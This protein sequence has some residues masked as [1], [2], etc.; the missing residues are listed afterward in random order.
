VVRVRTVAEDAA[1]GSLL[2]VYRRVRER[3]GA[4]PNIAKVQPQR[5]TVG[6]TEPFHSDPE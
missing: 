4:V 6:L 2:E 1:P 5:P 3:A